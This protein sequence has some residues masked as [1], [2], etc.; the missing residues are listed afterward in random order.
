MLIIKRARRFAVL[1]VFVL[2]GVGAT[3]D[4]A[5]A[6]DHT[7]V[8]GKGT[9]V[10]QD[11]TVLH[12]NVDV[13]STGSA[14]VSGRLL[15]TFRFG[16]ESASQ[17]VNAKATCLMTVGS[18]VLVGG[19]VVNSATSAGSDF[20]HFVL[21][22]EDGGQTSDRVGSVRF[23]GLPPEADPCAEIAPF[24]AFIARAP[25]EKGDVSFSP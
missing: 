17:T 14:V 6:A 3:S 1:F 20:S 19:P 22:L 21:I 8:S 15:G 5:S 10:E 2:A 12:I 4:P 9:T 24:A 25:L 18:L 11:G 23:V 7:S 16:E 13:E